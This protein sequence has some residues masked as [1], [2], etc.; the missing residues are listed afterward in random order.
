MSDEPQDEAASGEPEGA[1]AD[2]EE[3]VVGWPIKRQATP[4]QAIVAI[5]FIFFLGVAVG[6][7]L[8]S[9]F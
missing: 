3:E 9:T 7:L 1:E 6:F 8:C 2:A 5:G 4:Q